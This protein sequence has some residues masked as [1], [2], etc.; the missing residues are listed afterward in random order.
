MNQQRTF[1]SLKDAVLDE[2]QKQLDKLN[3]ANASHDDQRPAYRAAE[4]TFWNAWTKSAPELQD[5]TK[6]Y[7]DGAIMCSDLWFEPFLKAKEEQH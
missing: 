1:T 4:V 3:L 2:V 5:R 6:H 7:A